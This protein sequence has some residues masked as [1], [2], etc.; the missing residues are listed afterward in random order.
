[1]KLRTT[2]KKLLTAFA[3]LIIAA[4]C[5]SPPKLPM[6]SE[7]K[8]SPP[9]ED[10]PGYSAVSDEGVYDNAALR[11]S[12]RH[13][14]SNDAVY[15]KGESGFLTALIEGDYV[16]IR[17]SIENKSSAAKVI[18][19]PAYVAL[20]DNAA[21]YKKPLDYTDLYDIVKENDETGGKLTGIKGRIFDLT[22]TVAPG[23]K[24]SKLLIFKPFIEEASSAE[25]VI[26]NIYVGKD[27]VNVKFP[28]K[29]KTVEKKYTEK[30]D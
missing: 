27:T 30:K 8:P 13:L 14:K 18:F 3:P 22:A 25:L 7:L 23:G 16:L 28:F 5:A 24:T 10:L 15:A 26:K 29:V 19:N 9:D 21:N 12:A 17:L 6:T 11:I 2:L 1:M 4:S 20:M